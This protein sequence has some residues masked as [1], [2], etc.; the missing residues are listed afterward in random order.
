MHYVACACPEAMRGAPE[1]VDYL[2]RAALDV[3]ASAPSSLAVRWDD[4]HVLFIASL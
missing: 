3:L 4:G 2:V 1:R